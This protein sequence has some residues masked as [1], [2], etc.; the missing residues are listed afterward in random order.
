[1]ESFTSVYSCTKDVMA[2]AEEEQQQSLAHVFFFTHAA[3][4]HLD[5]GNNGN[6]LD[7]HVHKLF[8]YSVLI[9]YPLCGMNLM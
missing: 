8:N 6:S 3:F 9:N 7:Q 5:Y 2:M 1:M 4:S